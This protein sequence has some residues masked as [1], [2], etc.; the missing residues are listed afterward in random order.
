MGPCTLKSDYYEQCWGEL[1]LFRN[2]YTYE[3]G[4]W[5][6]CPS[7]T[8]AIQGQCIDPK[9]LPVD[10]TCPLS[11][12]NPVDVLTGRKHEKVTD[13]TSG[14]AYPLTLER[15]YSSFTTIVGAPRRSS[16]GPAWRTNFDAAASW[17]ADKLEMAGNI[18][19]VLPNSLV[20]S[21]ANY[22]GW[23]PV[24]PSWNG[25]YFTWDK[26]KLRT[27]ID[28]SL[29]VSS[30]GL[31]LRIQDG[32]RYLFNA[33]GQL[34][35]ILYVGGY[36]QSLSYADGL[37]VRVTDNLG[38]W[39]AF[40]YGQ[41]NV[42]DQ[43]I[44]VTT[45][46]GTQ[47]LYSYEDRYAL[48]TPPGYP[49]RPYSYDYFALKS[50][51]Y[52]DSTP[53]P[54][55]NPRQV[56]SY[57]DDPDNPFL[58]ASITDERG[59]VTASWTYDDKLRATSSRHAGGADLWQFA[60]DDAG[61]KVTVT[62]PLGRKTVYAYTRVMDVIRRLTAVNGIATTNC[63]QSDTVYSYN[64][65]GFR[66]EARDAEG[67]ITKW[68]RN[69]RGLP[70]TETEGFNT[71]AAR[72]RTMTW[73]ATRPLVTSLVEPGK[74]T[75]IAYDAQGK[76]TSLRLTD[77]G[78]QTVP[79][80]TKGRSSTTSFTY[81]V[82]P[83]PGPAPGEFQNLPAV[84][85][86]LRNPSAATGL[87]GWTAAGTVASASDD[88]CSGFTC[89][90]ITGASEASLTQVVT[91]PPGNNTE[92]D[93]G[94]RG[95]T[96]TWRDVTT[97]AKIMVDVAF[98]DGA[99][100]LL[101]GAPRSFTITSQ[102]SWTTRRLDV[103]T[104]PAN[105]RALRISF[106]SRPSYD[107]AVAYGNAA[108]LTDIAA[109]LVPRAHVPADMA[110]VLTVVD[111]PLPGPSDTTRYGY[112][113]AG[114]LVSVTN[115]L[116]HTTRITKLDAGGRPLSVTDPNGVVSNLY[117]DA[118]GRLT[119]V[120]VNPGAGQAKTII[121]YD[122]AGQV[123][124]VT[125][126]D[127]S[128]LTYVWSDARRLT[129]V[130]NNAGERIDYTYNDNGDVTSRTV[131]SSTGTIARQQSA[132][133]DE[134]GRLMRSIGAAGQ[135]TLLQYDRTDNLTTVQDPRGGLFGYA[136][137]G[138]Q[139]LASVTDQTGASVKLAR[140]GQG[141][142]TAYSDPRGITTSYVR[143]GFGE[144]I[145]ESGPDFGTTVIARDE[146]GL[147]TRIT[148][149]R[150]IVTQ[151][152]YDA[153]GRLVKEAYS[154]DPKQNVTYF[155]DDTANGNRGIG[156]LTGITDASGSLSRTY[157][158]LGRISS[159]TRVIAGKSYV[160]SYGYNTAGRVT[161]VVYPSGRVVTY[162]RNALGRVSAIA[163]SAS[164]T[165]PV[166]TVANNL[167]WSPM[168]SR[169]TAIKHGNGLAT[170]MTY[171]GDGRIASLK[172]VDGTRRLSQLTYAYGD[173]MNLT[174]VNDN[175]MAANSLGLAYDAA[176]RLVYASGPWGSLTYGYT[177]NGDRTREVLTSPGGSALTTL[178]SYPANSN[179]LAKTSVGSL[180][181]R[182]FSYDAAG[183]LATQTMGPLQLIFTYNLRNRPVTLTRTGDGTQKSSYAYNAL[184]QMVQRSTTAPGGPSGTVHYIYGLDGALLAEAD[185]ATGATLRDYIWLPLNDASPAADN[186]N[187][188]G[189]SPPPLPLA[190]VTGV[191]TAK[192]SLLMVHADHLG[193]PIRLTDATRAT[194]WQASY[195]P[196]GQPWQVTG[197][198]EQNLR[199][200]GQ[201]FLIESGL[202]YNWHRFYDPAT[203]RYTQPDPLRFV[204]GP[205]VYSYGKNRPLNQ[206][207]IEGL[208][209]GGG[210][211]LP[212]STPP[213][214]SGGQLCF[215]DCEA[216]RK[217]CDALCRIAKY[218]PDMPYIWG[219]SYDKCMR[220]CI[221]SNCG[222]NKV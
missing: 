129:A 113:V 4:A 173:G 52:P 206:V 58:L 25:Y 95:L 43:V 177:R 165:A 103:G 5:L 65:N 180:T 69:S 74:T 184:E 162:S 63:A 126:P 107:Y 26:D 106:R 56:Y 151:L 164:A 22:G 199:F 72:T 145:Q 42:P 167:A 222:G 147:P 198:V 176:Q 217:A 117:Y 133:F 71:P 88:P 68:T 100:N 190:L 192:P 171:D 134:L 213:Q 216:E 146:R 111:G 51:T 130:I 196:F 32:T 109:L 97:Y 142:V 158:A 60:Y 110:E 24:V 212:H 39:L 94:L 91:L 73:D 76:V 44:K 9:D 153:A 14:G 208:V 59:V 125:A 64:A 211:G 31:V 188:E 8:T 19:I 163:T 189:A 204:D 114:N 99:R 123:T 50:V 75:D 148:S 156:R 55:D 57:V 136:Y 108:Y 179:R 36:S 185:G 124:R 7:G 128:Y 155:Y 182:L 141:E 86:T 13:W 77:T 37:M 127:G 219:G 89:F 83:L 119:M 161:A 70:L 121:A 140:D 120:I 21:F 154:A 170:A 18:H 45:S 48:N 101:D 221:S 115:E 78:T 33:S 104:I 46:D 112:D 181:T 28:V 220:G 157:D 17:N 218:D 53:S 67:R 90:K 172:L 102:S 49:V 80:S 2:L 1:R 15:N 175:V 81:A 214:P 92:V 10:Q 23:K 169:L 197:T 150:G 93:R 137:D 122:A 118:R 200:P 166:E 105:T 11:L 194:V 61:N 193:R 209:T 62:N 96:I 116:G 144:I 41:P 183:N 178:M 34:V 210:S 98:L 160:T 40:A 215:D 54:A 195:D 12:G 30:T 85:I 203:G 16:L 47:I 191:N 87:V 84:P 6:D 131:K 138:L 29:S 187:E 168:S 159:E 149:P 3:F 139:N 174:A 82:V 201:Y 143:N 79:Y 35:Q 202:S 135:H 205:S 132:L 207:D 27:D 66:S 152:A 38:R 186:D 20:Y